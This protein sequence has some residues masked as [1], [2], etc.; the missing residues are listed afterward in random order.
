[1]IPH[2]AISTVENSFQRLDPLEVPGWDR[3]LSSRPGQCF[4]HSSAWAGVLRDTYGH[5]PFYFTR[6]EG[7][8]LEALIPVMEVASPLTG[9]RGVSLPFSDECS[10]VAGDTIPSGKLLEEVLAFGRARRWR[11]FECRGDCG[12]GRDG[13][14]QPSS[15]FFGHELDLTVGEK[16]L[17]SQL[18]SD[19]R[20]AIRKAQKAGLKVELSQTLESV[21]TYYKLHCKTRKRHGLPPQPFVFFL[22]IFR[23][24]LARRLGVVVLASLKNAPVAGAIF[25]NFG[26]QVLYKF[27]ASDAKFQSSRGNNLVMWEAIKWFAEK[28]YERMRFGRTSIGNQGL[29]RYKLGFG[30]REYPISY[31]RY[32]FRSNG[33]VTGTD[34]SSGWHT[35]LFGSLPIW[36]LGIVGRLVYPHLS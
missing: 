35:R 17:F 22:N 30:T 36:A 27:G 8:N 16:Q 33:Y 20:R 28:G 11:Y 34:R 24:V 14:P 12:G 23:H 4:F 6:S 29:R 5:R 3:L 18:G 13:R 9:T 21:R 19:V 26:R 10:V 2:K 32:D 25:C 7:A 15:S 1:M 31:L